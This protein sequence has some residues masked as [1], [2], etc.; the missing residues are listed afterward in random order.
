MLEDVP[1]P[2][3][4]FDVITMFDVVEHLYN[5]VDALKKI[6]RLLKPGGVVYLLTPD[7]ESVFAKL[8]GKY[9]FEIK[10]KEHIYYFSK[11]TL[12][13]LFEK[14]GFTPLA[15]KKTGKVLTFE[16]ISTILRKENPFFAGLLR[17]LTKWTPF[18]KTNIA[19]PAGFI[20]GVGIK[21]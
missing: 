18:Y 20:A 16:Y 11:S 12:R 19:Y 9:W 2:E 1:F 13:L 5:P 10:P 17:G 21:K 7:C 3:N 4:N 8:M 15:M 6:C 14:S